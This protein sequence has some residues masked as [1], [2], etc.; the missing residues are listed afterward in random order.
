MQDA[1]YN[2]EMRGPKTAART[3]NDVAE[4]ESVVEREIC[5]FVEPAIAFC[6]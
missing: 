6:C 3:R 4:S 5:V 2:R 1:L